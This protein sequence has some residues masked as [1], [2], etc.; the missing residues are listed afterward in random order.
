[1]RAFVQEKITALTSS[2]PHSIRGAVREREGP[3]VSGDMTSSILPA[4]VASSNDRYVSIKGEPGGV[5]PGRIPRRAPSEYFPLSSAQQRLWFM[6]KL[7]PNLPLYHVP[8]V[9]RFRVPVDTDVLREAI[10]DLA[11]RHEVL[12]AS[13]DLVDSAPVQRLASTLRPD[14]EIVDLRSTPATTRTATWAHAASQV[15]QRSFDLRVPPLFR[16]VLYQFADSDN[17]LLTVMHHIICDAWS[18]AIFARELQTLYYSR[19]SGETPR[20]DALPIRYS[21][22][23][24]WQRSAVCEAESTRQVSYWIDQLTDAPPSALPGVVERP[25][26]P[27]HQGASHSFSVAAGVLEGLRA[28]S[29]REG[30]TLFMTLLAAFKAFLSRYSGETDIIVGAPIAGR[31][32]PELEKLIGCFV[33]P[34]VFRSDLSGNPDFLRLLRRVKETCLDAY[35]NQDAPFEK[36][37]E[38][39]QPDRGSLRNPLFQVAFSLQNVGHAG[40]E[41]GSGLELPELSAGTAKFDLFLACNETADR[42]NCVWEYDTDLF[43][44]VDI[45]RFTVSFKNLLGAIAARP[46]RRLSDLAPL[47]AEEERLLGAWNVTRVE[48]PHRYFFEF[49]RI[50]CA[51]HPDRTAIVSSRECVTYNAL[52]RQSAGIAH[53]LTAVG[54]SKGDLVGIFCRRS[55]CFV[56]GI[57]G[58]MMVGA[59]YVPI[60]PDYPDA[61]VRI[62]VDEIPASVLLTERALAQRAAAFQHPIVVTDELPDADREFPR[63]AESADDLAYGIFTSGSTGRPK[64]A[65]V[66]HG[67]LAN[68]LLWYIQEFD[69]SEA[70][71]LLVVTSPSFDLTQKN[72]LAPLLVGAEVHLSAPGEFEP[73]NIA[74]TI[75]ADRISILNATPS[76]FYAVADASH[77]RRSFTPLRLVVLGGEPINARRLLPLVRTPGFRAQIVNTYGPTECTDVVAFYPI[78]DIEDFVDNR[79]PIGRPVDNVQLHIL[80]DNLCRVP[81]GAPGEL[82]VTGTAVGAGYLND[83]SLSAKRLLHRP[84]LAESPGPIYRTGDRARYM[85]DGNIDFLGRMDSQ[86]KLRGFRIELGEVE[87]ALSAHA[88]VHE[89]VVAPFETR[90]GEVRLA[91]FVVPDPQSA[92]TVTEFLRMVRTG[93]LAGHPICELPNNM[94]IV[95]QNRSETD[96]LFHELFERRSYFR[97][98]IEITPDAIVFDVGANIGLFSLSLP[99][100][101]HAP[102]VFAFEPIPPIFNALRLNMQAYGMDATLF[103]FGLSSEAKTVEFSYYP[104]ASI[105]SGQF[106]DQGEESA[107]V[108]R[109]LQAQAEIGAAPHLPDEKLSELLSERLVTEKYTRTVKTLSQ[110]IRDHAVKRIDLLKIDVEK[111]EYGVLQG[112][113]AAHWPLIDQVVIEAHDGDGTLAKV[114]TL[115]V[116]QG[117]QV[118]IEQDRV[119]ESSGMYCVYARRRPPSP[120][121]FATNE[122]EAPPRWESIEALKRELR[123]FAGDKLPDHMIPGLIVLVD[124]LPKTPSGKLDHKELRAL[125]E[126]QLRSRTKFAAPRSPAE[127]AVA[128]IWEEVLGIKPVGMFDHF[129]DDLGGDSLSATQ[130]IVRVSEALNRDLP[131]R[132][133]FEQPTIA[134]FCARLEEVA[135]SPPAAHGLTGA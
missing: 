124:E 43:V 73:R 4:V 42:L 99:R 77:D 50:S 82:C 55:P 130:V 69:L 102:K 64:L 107:T 19:I 133:M 13:F 5:P 6:D 62:M 31:T 32:Q 63:V 104:H 41:N 51:K 44:M 91:A 79:V 87:A 65:G 18:M 113:E 37:V 58:T 53:A 81:L 71:R 103:D 11:E 60:D 88:C 98:G 101:P 10:A 12:R 119:L 96:F 24:A 45:E 109:F 9:V 115:L 135:E 95:H 80:D 129:F 30:A 26:Y 123:R 97:H 52:L 22:F 38:V 84:Q 122:P 93:I 127:N 92:A 117:F 105:L 57:V 121:S 120:A 132:L 131:L 7:L 74:R 68:L 83:A 40:E 100:G 108:K 106:A 39:L 56:A 76:L 25:A 15:L 3:P 47:S 110:V 72:L 8:V 126:R 89:A 67:G 70:D 75:G 85:R 54:V 114:G 14:L 59:A 90:P 94:T 78:R 112:I 20:L 125:A 48:R 2:P 16:N 111:S 1:M 34:L 66:R 35:A 29:K 33:N 27:S 23:A 116:D 46:S 17:V 118:K 128:G 134:G 61:R 86:I 28:L 49:F 21:D 36:I